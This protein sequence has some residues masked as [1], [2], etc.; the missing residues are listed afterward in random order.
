MGALDEIIRCKNGDMSMLKTEK[1]L[2]FLTLTQQYHI[3]ME[4]VNSLEQVKSNF[5][6]AYVERTL[7]VLDAYEEEKL[8]GSQKQMLEEVLKWAETAKG[9]M[10]HQR[11]KWVQNGYNLAVHNIGSAQI[12]SAMNPNLEEKKKAV[13]YTLISTHGLIGQYIR[14][15]VTLSQSRP[16]Y[17]LTQKNLIDRQELIVLLKALNCCIISAVSENLWN[18]VKQQVYSAAESILNGDFTSEMPLKERLRA[19][20]NKSAA[21]GENFEGAFEMVSQN[22]KIQDVLVAVF[23]KCDLWYVEAAL[24][25]FSFEE[26]VKIFLFIFLLSVDKKI[27]H[28]SFEKLMGELYYNHKGKKRINIYKKRIIEKYLSS[29]SAE[30]ILC[31]VTHESEHIRH[32]LITDSSYDDTAFFTFVF[33]PAGESLIRFCVEA[34]KSGVLYEKAIVLLFDLFGL[35]KDAYDRFYEE[36][37][38]LSTM[39]QTIDYKKVIL[40]YV[41]GTNVIDIGPGGGALMDLIE[42]RL[43]DKNVTGIDISENVIDALSKKKQKENKK[44]TVQKGDAFHLADTVKA[45]SADTI[46]FCSIIHELFSYIETDG[47]KF[48]HETICSALKSAFHVLSPGGRIIIRDGIMTQPETLKRRIRFVSEDGMDFLKRYAN[49]FQGRQIQFETVGKNEV[50]MPVNDAMEF[51]YTYTWGE[52]SYV[53]E[54]NEQFGYFTPS[55]YKKFIKETLG[56]AVEIIEFRHYLQDGYTLALSQRI[57]FMNEH[58]AAVSLPDS[59]CLIVIQKKI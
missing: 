26:F 32:M 45:G 42:V 5:T 27:S 46:V 10:E 23:S 18:E 33:S 44:W 14:G 17:E 47:K 37:N 28:I 1:W 2:L 21:E 8:T 9:G 36:E 43:P 6:L 12:Y 35:R 41:C 49:D 54:I 56:E 40:D 57:E 24:Y 58:G 29:Y 48:N 22:K 3:N 52:E 50:I 39:N 13:I 53:H 51:L 20:R 30:D 55:R 19:L 4:R 11:L 15:E 38:Y 31:G 25:D 16:L 59:T 34:E 7:K